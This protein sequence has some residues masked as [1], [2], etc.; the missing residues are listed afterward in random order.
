MQQRVI[1][2]LGWLLVVGASC[3]RTSPVDGR[4][5]AVDAARAP[6]I[7]AAGAAPDAAHL[8]I[9][10]D[11]CADLAQGQLNQI[12]RTFE[13]CGEPLTE[14]DL[15]HLRWSEVQGCSGTRR[16]RDLL[17]VEASVAA[18]RVKYDQSAHLACKQLGRG[19]DGG[20]PTSAAQL[21][22]CPKILTGLVV[23]GGACSYSEECAGGAPCVAGARGSCAGACAKLKPE[24]AACDPILDW[25]GAGALCFPAD[26][27]PVCTRFDVSDAGPW[28]DRRAG[29]DESCDALPCDDCLECDPGL[30]VCR[31]VPKV[32]NSCEADA[33]SCQA[34]VLDCTAA[35]C[36]PRVELF[37]TDGRC[38]V[39]P[40]LGESCQAPAVILSNLDQQGNCL[41]DDTF[42][43][44]PAAGQPGV[45][46]SLPKLGESCGWDPDLAI[47]CSSGTCHSS[48]GRGTCVALAGD[49]E[50]CTT[51]S[52]AGELQCVDGACHPP[53]GTEGAECSQYG[54]CSGA[55]YCAVHD[56]GP[57]VCA[58]LRAAGEACERS[59]VCLSGSCVEGRCAAG[60]CASQGLDQGCNFGSAF[61]FYG[62]LVFFAAVLVRRRGSASGHR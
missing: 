8:E 43:K 2:L 15:K 12:L 22:P 56:A 10:A 27:G 26:A 16:E 59:G 42:C 44:R 30:H 61:E 7:D 31:P 48:G 41:W 57:S 28:V 46:A 11:L 21:E 58:P 13:R 19:W 35:G 52:C 9:L 36:W 29:L 53:P 39:K 49:G 55:F 25:C 32:G 47:S 50:P 14:E 3:G 24:G 20:M 37:C 62:L 1:F 4:A 6:D 33:A 60:P 54:A 45:C 5:A 18:G 51:G 40:R 17:R 34:H 23:A 38:A